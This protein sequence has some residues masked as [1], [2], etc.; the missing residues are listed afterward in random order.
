MFNEV[1]AP[2]NDK[3]SSIK[4]DDV[5]I[6]LRGIN[7]ACGVTSDFLKRYPSFFFRKALKSAVDFYRPF[8]V[9]RFG[10]KVD[11]L[12]ADSAYSVVEELMHLIVHGS[13]MPLMRRIVEVKK[14]NNPEEVGLLYRNGFVFNLVPF[15]G[16]FTVF[17]SAK[18]YFE[19]TNQPDVV[20][21]L[22][23][24]FFNVPLVISLLLEL[25]ID[26][27]S[28]F[29]NG[30]DYLYTPL[31][32]DAINNSLKI[33][34]MTIFTLGQLG[35]KRME[36]SGFGRAMLLVHAAVFM[37]QMTY[38]LKQQ[39]QVFSLFRPKSSDSKWLARDTIWGISKEGLKIG[40]Q[41][42]TEGIKDIIIASYLGLDGPNGKDGKQALDALR[43]VKPFTLLISIPAFSWGR[44]AN[45]LTSW[46]NKH[47]MPMITDHISKFTL[48]VGSIIAFS[49]AAMNGLA[50]KYM[51]GTLLNN[52][53]AD[54]QVKFTMACHMLV[55][56]SAYEACNST[57]RFCR[58]ILIAHGL[59]SLQLF[60][61][62]TSAIINVGML[63]LLNKQPDLFYLLREYPNETLLG[64]QNVA[65][66]IL[67]VSLLTMLHYYNQKS[68]QEINAEVLPTEEASQLSSSI[69]SCLPGFL[70]FCQQKDGYVAVST[71]S[72]CLE[73]HPVSIASSI[74]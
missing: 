73:E 68:M 64:T 29:L 18:Q 35:I 52:S 21:D 38:L 45:Y 65:V 20:I 43:V 5:E 13:Q 72:S 32:F 40:A 26:Y 48:I 62:V 53:T 12:A 47:N 3:I 50:A 74:P 2:I 17:L 34:F 58:Q 67:T 24:D 8:L 19:W 69:R 11:Y 1:E 14:S 7:S 42:L 6:D 41:S 16:I 55:L 71:I 36:F 22:A 9:V 63:V 44:T 46:T 49:I 51:V 57:K 30:L 54:E 23:D 31:F 60:L 28:I 27:N 10:N 66:A 39:F 61:T 4:K 33:G 59:Y 25:L 15:I 37:G 70:N 56:Y